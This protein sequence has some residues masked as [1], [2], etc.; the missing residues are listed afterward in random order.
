MVGRGGLTRVKT[1][2]FY[3]FFFHGASVKALAAACRTTSIELDENQIYSFF[4]KSSPEE[5][6]SRRLQ[7]GG[8]VEAL[9][10]PSWGGGGPPS[11]RFPSDTVTPTPPVANEQ[12]RFW[13]RARALANAGD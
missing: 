5:N 7:P 10:I 13:P 2:I 4:L 6:W 11:R 9:L 1:G 3:I 12:K 8:V